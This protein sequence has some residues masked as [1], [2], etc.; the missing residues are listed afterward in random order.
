MKQAADHSADHRRRERLHHFRAGSRAPHDRQQT[1]DDRGD[2]HHFRTQAQ[3]RAFLD[4]GNEICV[5]EAGTN[6]SASS[7]KR[8]LQI[9]DHDDAGLDGGAEERDVADPDGDAEIV[10]EQVLQKD[11][12]GQREGH[13]EDDVRGF[14]RVAIDDVKQEENDEQA[15]PAR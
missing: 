14:L 2:G 5:A 13:G 7:F 3:A 15:R 4:G 11:A 6:S 9:D 1:G 10:A 12:A 8:F